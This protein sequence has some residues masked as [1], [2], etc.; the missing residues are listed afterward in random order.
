MKKIIRLTESDLVRLVKR[1]IKEED[2]GTLL[3]NIKG[4]LTN[5][6]FKYYSE[7][8]RHVL[9]YKDGENI[10]TVWVSTNSMESKPYSVVSILLKPNYEANPGYERSRFDRTYTDIGED[11]GPKRYASDQYKLLLNDVKTSMKKITRA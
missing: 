10:I 6:G 11:G 2:N 9:K 5:L 8:Q 7:D 4:E 1:I 3:N